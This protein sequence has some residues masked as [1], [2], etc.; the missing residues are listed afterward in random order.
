MVVVHNNNY[1]ISQLMMN[2]MGFYNQYGRHCTKIQ[3]VERI[4][5]TEK[6]PLALLND[7]MLCCGSNLKGAIASSKRILGEKIQMRP[8]MVNP[9]LKIC[10][11]THPSPN[12]DDEKP[13]VIFRFLPNSV[14]F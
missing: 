13:E 1:I 10:V 7:S 2:M 6:S 12:H 14:P 9:M 5:I 4:V 11:F 3:E 8:L